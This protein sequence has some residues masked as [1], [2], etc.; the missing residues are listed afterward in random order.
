MSPKSRLPPIKAKG[1]KFGSGT[2]SGPSS[3][4]NDSKEEKKK[5]EEGSLPFLDNVCCNLCNESFFDGIAKSKIY[6]LTTCGHIVCD[7]DEHHHKE[8]TCTVCGKTKIH[9]V[10]ME[11]GNLQPAQEK[12][13]YNPI[14]RL[15]LLEA[16][17]MKHIKVIQDDVTELSSLRTI[18]SFQEKQHKRTR[19]IYKQELDKER[20][21]TERLRNELDIHITENV[22]LKQANKELQARLDMPPPPLPRSSLQASGVFETPR[23]SPVYG[24]GLNQSLPRIQ[25]EEE[26][27]SAKRQRVEQNGFPPELLAPSTPIPTRPP[28]IIGGRIYQTP[29]PHHVDPHQS[30]DGY[31]PMLPRA[32]PSKHELERYRYNSTPVTAISPQVYSQGYIQG[33]GRIT[34][35][36][37]ETP[38]VYR[39]YSAQGTH[40]RS[41]AQRQNYRFSQDG[42]SP[43]NLYDDN[44]QDYGSGEY[45][46]SDQ[47]KVSLNLARKRPYPS[48]F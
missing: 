2:S 7:D 20:A 5:E 35:M 42:W 46:A 12:F 21:E 29:Q 34:P 32:G 17:I 19:L 33:N 22:E 40:R 18:Y 27:S 24:S 9:A 44:R 28:S 8:G 16:E 14:S 31:D 10:S 1:L 6:W 41:E 45:D 23:Q 30:F 4:G 26:N 37:G 15:K 11:Q 25:E 36:Q 48:Q 13:L 38:N 47:P 43:N 39:P 3:V